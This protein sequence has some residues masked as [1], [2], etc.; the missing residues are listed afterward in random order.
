LGLL[1]SAIW[2][3]VQLPPVPEQVGCVIVGMVVEVLVEG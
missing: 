1:L 2:T 3:A